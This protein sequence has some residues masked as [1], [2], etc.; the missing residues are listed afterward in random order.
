MAKLTV[1]KINEM[2]RGVAMEEIAKNGLTN[3][4]QIEG[5]KF[6]KD[7]E[8][9][10]EEGIM[11][12]TVRIDIVVPKLEEG[13]N[14]EFLAEDYQLRLKEKEENAK[15]KAEAKAKKIA[16]DQKKRAEKQA[17]ESNPIIKRTIKE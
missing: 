16:R 1:A 11:T 5:T 3:F 10:T 12:K 4:L 14:A 9:E 8:F 13:E 2:A 7:F 15:I 17:N 6:A